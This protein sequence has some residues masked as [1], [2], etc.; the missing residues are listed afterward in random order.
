[1]YYKITK[2]ATIHMI[3][4]SWSAEEEYFKTELIHKKTDRTE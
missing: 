1:M 2:S 4:H 3:S